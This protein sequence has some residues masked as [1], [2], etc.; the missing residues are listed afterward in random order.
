MARYVWNYAGVIT[1]AIEIGDVDLSDIIASLAL[2]ATGLIYTLGYLRTKGSEENKIKSEQIKMAR[3]YMDTMEAAW[4]ETLNWQIDHPFKDD[5]LDDE[6]RYTISIRT[7]ATVLVLSAIALVVATVSN[8]L[9]QVEMTP[10]SMAQISASVFMNVT[11]S[12][13]SSIVIEN[14]SV[15]EE[16]GSLL[17]L[18]AN[19]IRANNEELKDLLLEVEEEE[20]ELPAEEIVEESSDDGGE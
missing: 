16:K 20:E 2:F 6:R 18:A 1:V 7:F 12:N 17:V 4:D 13:G 19:Q 5:D 9:G 3:G 10:E 11:F 15:T 8:A 14:Q